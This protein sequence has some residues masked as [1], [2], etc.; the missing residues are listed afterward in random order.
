MKALTN[1]SDDEL[2]DE[3][4]KAGDKLQEAKDRVREFHDEHQRRL[5]EE[6]ARQRMESMNDTE[7]AALRQMLETEGI[8]SEEA[9]NE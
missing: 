4:T 6:A 1:M 5:V 2:M 3:W 8:E 7:R 9:V